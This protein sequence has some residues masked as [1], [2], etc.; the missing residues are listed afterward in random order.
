MFRKEIFTAFTAL[1]FAAPAFAAAPVALRDGLLWAEV[2]CAGAKLHFVV[3]TGAGSSCVNLAAARRLG[4]RLGG[5]LDVAGVDGQT[6]GYRCIGFHATLGGMRLPEEVVALDLSGP[7]RACSEQIDGLIGADFFRGRV[8]R[9]DYARGVLSDEPALREAWRGTPLRFAN[10]VIC[11]HVAMN[12][13]RARWTRLD[14][15]CTDALEWCAEAGSRPAANTGKTVA[16]AAFPRGTM[17]AEVTVGTARLDGV[18]V[19]VRDREIFPGEAGLLGNGT[20][21]NFRVTIDGIGR[22]LVLDP[23]R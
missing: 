20:L 15:G 3:D 11:V 5:A 10:G 6:T 16:L 22:R 14:T 4:L 1:A 21:S 23:C 19:Q 9:I 12:G 7:A 2:E 13:G 8:V 17:R 18:P